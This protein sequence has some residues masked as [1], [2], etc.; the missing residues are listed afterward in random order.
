MAQVWARVPGH[1]EAESNSAVGRG[2]QESF[3]EKALRGALDAEVVFVK[4]RGTVGWGSRP[5]SGTKAGRR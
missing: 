4:D 2:W 1:Q 5:G 3:S